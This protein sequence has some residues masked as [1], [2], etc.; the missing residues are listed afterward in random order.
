MMNFSFPGNAKIFT[1]LLLQV[2]NADVLDS[3][4]TTELVFD[5]TRDRDIIEKVKEKSLKTILI[6]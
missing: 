3:E 6:D 1:F 2:I 5:F 4:W